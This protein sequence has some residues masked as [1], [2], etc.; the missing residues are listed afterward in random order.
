[1]RV[2]LAA[3]LSALLLYA[4]DTPEKAQLRATEKYCYSLDF[5]TS[6]GN[7]F[8]CLKALP[9]KKRSRLCTVS[10]GGQRVFLGM[11]ECYQTLP[12]KEVHGYW[13]RGFQLS[14]FHATLDA[15]ASRSEAGAVFLELSARAHKE[16]EGYSPRRDPRVFEVTFIGVVSTAPGLYYLDADRGVYAS[17]FTK[18]ND[19]TERVF[20]AH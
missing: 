5:A 1:M 20:G 7:Y 2:Q 16:A 9:V 6:N 4:C 15:I 14:E 11:P 8:D 18:I 19:I 12:Q 10:L 3:G 13:V 17:S